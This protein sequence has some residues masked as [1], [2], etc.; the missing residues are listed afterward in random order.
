MLLALGPA[1]LEAPPCNGRTDRAADVP[2]ALAP[3]EARPA[4]DA[5]QALRVREVNPQPAEEGAAGLRDLPAVRIEEN[6]L[7]FG[8]AVRQPDAEPAREMIVAGSRPRHRFVA[9]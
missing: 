4:E 6:L 5:A 9:A 7:P 3:I 2:A 1:G 8:K